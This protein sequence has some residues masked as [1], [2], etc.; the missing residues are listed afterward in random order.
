MSPLSSGDDTRPA[1][2]PLEERRSPIIDRLADELGAA[3]V[4]SEVLPQRDIWV[5]V[6]RDAWA[7]TAR[8]LREGLGFTYFC[9]LSAI[10]WMPSP[11]GKSEDDF[12]PD[13]ASASE[14]AGV[15]PSMRTE[16]YEHGVTGGDTRLQLLARVESP[17]TGIGIT[18]KADVPDDD[19]TAPTWSRTYAGADWHERE[20]WEMFGI[21]FTGHPNLIH[22]YLPGEFEGY[23]LRKDFPLL[24]RMVKPWP[25]LVDVEP[26]PGE[27]PEDGEGADAEAA[28]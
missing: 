13:V 5:R 6:T 19:P 23:P 8:V 16:T 15:E 20:T 24:S 9:F 26:M 10:D 28:E 27:D 12:N 3:V 4:S 18:V 25:G 14:P 1:G 2:P 21:T 17:G 11:Y 7:D 22:I